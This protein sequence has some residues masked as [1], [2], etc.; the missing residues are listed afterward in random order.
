MYFLLP[1]VLNTLCTVLMLRQMQKISKQ[2]AKMVG[3][4]ENVHAKLDLATTITLVIVSIVHFAFVMPVVIF[5]IYTRIL[6]ADPTASSEMLE[7]ISNIF[8]SLLNITNISNG[9]SFYVYFARVKSFRDQLC[10][11]FCCRCNSA[12]S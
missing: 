4:K 10:K 3:D 2:R 6:F 12:E 8:S 1:G 7:D 11:I 5:G 9:I